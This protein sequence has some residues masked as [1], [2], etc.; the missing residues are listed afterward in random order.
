VNAVNEM[1]EMELMVALKDEDLWVRAAAGNASATEAVLRIAA[2]D[3][4]ER[5]REAVATNSKAGKATRIMS[6]L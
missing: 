5:V 3:P 6:V 4:D 2:L 1:N